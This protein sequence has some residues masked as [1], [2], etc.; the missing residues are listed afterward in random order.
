[1]MESEDMKALER[2]VHPWLDNR[3]IPLQRYKNLQAHDKVVLHNLVCIPT[4]PTTASE[5]RAL[6]RKLCAQES[7]AGRK[8]IDPVDSMTDENLRAFF[9]PLTPSQGRLLVDWGCE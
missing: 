4:H 6:Y 9:S 7:I 5:R 8:A 3:A 1:M 2:Q